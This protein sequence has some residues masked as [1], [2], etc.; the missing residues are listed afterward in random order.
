MPRNDVRSLLLTPA[1]LFIL[2][3]AERADAQ[4]RFTL[5]K[6]YLDADNNVHLAYTDGDEVHPKE[7]GQAGCESLK[8]AEDKQTVGWLVDFENELTTYPIALTLVV[9][10]DK[11]VVQ[12]FGDSDTDVIEDW[13]FWAGGKQVA[14]VTN[15]LHGG[16]R[17]HYELHDVEKGTLLG[18][19]D[20]PLNQAS[21][22]W[23]RGLWDEDAE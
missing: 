7:K 18:K 22:A 6:A 17:A 23:A 5:S 15:A 19:W 9:F 13:H 16:G 10:R 2:I 11:K 3:G 20:G 14:F 1:L 8:V 12:R 21:P 4:A